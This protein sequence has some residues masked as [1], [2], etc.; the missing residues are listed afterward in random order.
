MQISPVSDSSSSGSTA[1]SASTAA[2]GL[3]FQS[4]LQIILTQLT[5]QDP[6]KPMDNFEFVSQLAQFSQLE[7]SQQLNTTVSSLLTSQTSTQ[8]LGLLGHTVS[9]TSG[10]NSSTVTSGSVTAVNFSSSGPSLTI[11]TSSGQ[12]LANVALSSVT[13]VQ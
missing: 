2:Y 5:Y 13:S 12:V 11:T 7:E 8:A 6:L 4:L 10:S 9:L 3:N 1:S